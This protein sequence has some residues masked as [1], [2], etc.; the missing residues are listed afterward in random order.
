MIITFA[1]HSDIYLSDDLKKTVRE[2]ILNN[3]A[4]VT[5]VT[6]YL[7][8]YGNFDDICASICKELKQEN[9]SIEVVYVTPYIS[10]L[11]QAKIKEMISSGLCDTSIYPPIENVPLR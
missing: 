8:G 11:E 2:V 1:G 5:A 7:G 4:N 10:L 3:I 6:F 9:D